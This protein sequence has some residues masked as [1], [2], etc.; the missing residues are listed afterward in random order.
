MTLALRFYEFQTL[1]H[2]IRTFCNLALAYHFWHSSTSVFNSSP[3]KSLEDWKQGVYIL[4]LG[5][6]LPYTSPHPMHHILMHR[7]CTC[8]LTMHM[9]M[10]AHKHVQIYSLLACLI[11]TS[12][13]RVS[14]VLVPIEILCPP[15]SQPH[16]I[17][18]SL[19][20][21]TPLL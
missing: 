1:K 3:T 12:S 13:F 18:I 7:G 17:L 5:R 9:C 6:K 21:H 2:G 4:L 16:Q 15:I 20:G 10:D 11:P 19:M 14:S 8:C